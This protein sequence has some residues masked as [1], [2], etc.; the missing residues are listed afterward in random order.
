MR[1]LAAGFASV[2]TEKAWVLKDG[3]NLPSTVVDASGRGI[4]VIEAGAR[5]LLGS[6]TGGVGGPPSKVLGQPRDPQR[7]PGARWVGGR[8]WPSV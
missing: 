8:L 7:P 3:D 5:A 2:R 4:E 1:G 6:R